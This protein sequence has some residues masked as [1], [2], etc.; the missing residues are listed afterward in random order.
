MGVLFCLPTGPA[1]I[2]LVSAAG[3]Y[4]ADPS[5]DEDGPAAG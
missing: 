1:V 2:D 4:R 5:A 3:I